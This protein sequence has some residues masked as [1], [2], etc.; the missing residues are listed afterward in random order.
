MDEA[1]DKL[2]RNFLFVSSL[3][4]GFWWVGAKPSETISLFGIHLGSID[5]NRLWSAAA[6]IIVYCWMR[7]HFSESRRARWAD[8]KEDHARRVR[9]AVMRYL[10]RHDADGFKE[11]QLQKGRRS[12]LTAEDFC[13]RLGD[14]AGWV[15]NYVSAPWQD[16]EFGRE[17]PEAAFDPMSEPCSSY[18]IPYPTR[19]WLMLKTF[20]LTCACC[21]G[22]FEVLLPYLVG[23]AA[24]VVAFMSFWP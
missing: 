3:A 22:A 9:T 23:A 14:G 21:E 10:A 11:R 24:L 17:M 18:S 5:V 2:R 20:V 15:G 16:I 8:Y 1:P 13:V 4:F 19:C 7:Y 6:A 12:E